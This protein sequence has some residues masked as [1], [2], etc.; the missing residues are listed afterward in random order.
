MAA[1]LP[2]V[3]AGA[4]ACCGGWG[5]QLD[6]PEVQDWSFKLAQCR[7]EGRDAGSFDVYEACKRRMKR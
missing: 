4:L 7:A 3:L 1:A 6:D 5:S 2:V